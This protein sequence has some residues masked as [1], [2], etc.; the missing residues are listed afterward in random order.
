MAENIKGIAFYWNTDSEGIIQSYSLKT[1]QQE[2]IFLDVESSLTFVSEL[3]Y[4]QTG[5]IDRRFMAEC[6]EAMANW[7][8]DNILPAWRVKD[9]RDTA[10]LNRRLGGA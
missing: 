2:Y 6:Y 4:R 3:L 1:D 5:K 7:A 10:A 8:R 9:Y